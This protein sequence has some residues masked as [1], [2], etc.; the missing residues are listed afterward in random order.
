MTLKGATDEELTRAVKHSMVVIDAYKHKLDYKKSE[1]DNGI[2][3]LK[4]KYQ[5][6][7]D[8]NG[9]VKTGGASTLLS[10]AKGTER[11]DKRVG[12]PKVN[13]KGKEWYDPN[14]PEGALIYN[15]VKETYVDKNGKTQYRTEKS[16]KM[17]EASDARALSSGTPKE[18]LYAD[19][20]NS[21]KAMANRA[22][23]EMVT[24][25]RLEHSRDAAKEYAPEVQSLKDKLNK[26]LLNAPKE[27]QAQLLANSIVNEKKKANPDMEP[28]QL[29]KIKQQAIS[30]ARAK[31]GAQRETIVI[32]DREWEA[33]QKGAITDNLLSQMLNHADMDVLRQ[34]ATPRSNKELSS[35]KQAKLK[36]MIASGYSNSQIAEAL[37]ISSATVVNYL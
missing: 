20:A 23:K 22:R 25:G 19:Y 10:Q 33:I 7:I 31:F 1:Q 37:G 15:S 11:V 27:R 13:L 16:T 32:E 2:A 5:T 8:E 36:A 34:R 12:T 21:L 30:S 26:S 18:E 6:R 9:N 17:K 24:T 14:K 28:E 29:K 3:A 35:A 4:K